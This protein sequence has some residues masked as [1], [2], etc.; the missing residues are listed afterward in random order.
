MSDERRIRVPFGGAS[1]TGSSFGAEMRELV[2]R[3]GRLVCLIGLVVSL[4]L[5]VAGRLFFADPPVRALLDW[6]APL[7]AAHAVSF[8]LALAALQWGRGKDFPRKVVVPVLA[9][10]LLLAVGTPALF[11]PEVGV[12][13]AVALILFLHAAFVPCYASQVFLSAFAVAA[14]F[15]VPVVAREAAPGVAAYWAAEETGEFRLH[16]AWQTLGT[17][18]LAFVAALTSRTLY[19]LRRSAH[20]AERLGNYLIREEL[21]SGGMGT[22]YVARHALICRPTAVKVLEVDGGD[23]AATARFERE[24]QLSASL[25]H[26]NTITIYDFGRTSDDTFYYAMEFLE[27][28]DLQQ[29]V[30]RFGALPA[31]RAVHV[32]LQACGSLAE[33]HDRGIVHRDVKPSNVFLTRRGGLYDYVK[34][35]DF[36]LARELEARIDSAGDLTKTGVVVGTPR[37]MAP[38]SVRGNGRVD[39][40]A[41]IYNLG[42]VAYW[43]L[44][45]QPIF[46]DSSSLDLIVDHVKT[47]PP[48]PSR[49]SELPIPEALD[50]I[51]ARALEKDPADRFQSVSELEAALRAVPLESAWSHERARSWW[52]LH[53]PER[54]SDVACLEEAPPEDAPATGE[55]LPRG[56]R[57][58]TEAR[59]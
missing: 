5:L 13:F 58:A 31:E 1:T 43:M 2:W 32:L 41:D 22:V 3:R 16:V 21:G 42:A 44:T 15:A 10:N 27:G 23:G 30:E 33:A 24:V 48:P 51:V 28:M 9:F 7:Q 46:P 12:F 11:R 37:Y 55:V 56:I 40:R 53:A 45:G 25:T 6:Q 39:A 19:T 17:A 4:L 8:A 34:V 20:R 35:L 59:R 36:G 26:P 57:A 54:F 52:E 29:L 18:V 14:V 47:V 49:V 38:E 50:R